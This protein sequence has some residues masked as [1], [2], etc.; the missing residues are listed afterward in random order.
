MNNISRRDIKTLKRR[1]D[2]LSQRMEYNDMADTGRS[3]DA[4]EY[5]A[6]NHV[7]QLWEEENGKETEVSDIDE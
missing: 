5:N 1:R 3:Y 6:L 2:F 4:A 7:I